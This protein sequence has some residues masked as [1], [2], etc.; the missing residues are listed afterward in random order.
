KSGKHCLAFLSNSFLRWRGFF[1]IISCPARARQRAQGDRKLK[2]RGAAARWQRTFAGRSVRC[3]GERRLPEREPR[4]S[5][6][7]LSDREV[8][9]QWRLRRGPGRAV[10][11]AKQQSGL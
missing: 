10:G 4:Q 8:R 6:R 3:S 7:F 1:E 2:Q 11:T 9:G 5:R